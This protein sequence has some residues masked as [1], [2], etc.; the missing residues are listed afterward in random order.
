MPLTATGSDFSPPSPATLEAEVL[1]AMT[2]HIQRN[3]TIS[4]RVSSPTT[5]PSSPPPSSDWSW[6]PHG[7]PAP[8]QAAAYTRRS[9]A[10]EQE[11]GTRAQQWLNPLTNRTRESIRQRVG[12]GGGG[13]AGEGG[14]E[15]REGEG[16]GGEGLPLPLLVR[17]GDRLP[18]EEHTPMVGVVSVRAAMDAVAAA[19]VQAVPRAGR[20]PHGGHGLGPL[21]RAL[22]L[23]RTLTQR[24]RQ[25]RH[26][27][28]RAPEREASEVHGQRHQ[29]DVEEVHEHVDGER[30]TPFALATVQPPVEV[31]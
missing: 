8:A 4:S 1:H 16:G 30:P 29:P 5:F 7:A 10:S 22:A 27:L 28:P 12:V 23:P 19:R 11:A 31:R 14:A 20:P 21:P 18:V 13:G 25:P 3:T 24:V 26:A 6:T 17:L 9:S 15:E 2:Q